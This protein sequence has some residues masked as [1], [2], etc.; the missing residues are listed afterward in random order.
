MPLWFRSGK[1]SGK[2]SWQ[3]LVKSPVIKLDLTWY[4]T[5]SMLLQERLLIQPPRFRHFLNGWN[6]QSH[7]SSGS[8]G[9]LSKQWL[10]FEHTSLSEFSGSNPWIYYYFNLWREHL[11]VILMHVSVSTSWKVWI[12][13][14]VNNF[15][16][17]YDNYMTHVCARITYV[18]YK[19]KVYI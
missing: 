18:I 5:T 16:C 2:I 10:V 12:V 6:S 9:S 13:N 4:L 1:R 3:C 17:A 15:Y 14:I 19:I 8:T 11:S 7:V